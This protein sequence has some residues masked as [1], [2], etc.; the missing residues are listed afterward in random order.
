MLFER[1]QLHL[2]NYKIGKGRKKASVG[3]AAFVLRLFKEVIGDRPLKSVGAPEMLKFAKVVGQLPSVYANRPDLQAL[4]LSAVQAQAKKEKLAPLMLSTQAKYFQYLSTFLNWCVELGD[5]ETN[6]VRFINSARFKDPLKQGRQVFTK[7]D[8][9]LIID[10]LVALNPDE[11]HKFWGPLIA[12]FM[13]LRVNEVCQLYCEDI[14]WVKVTNE[15]N[16][17]EDVVCIRVSNLLP[18]QSV[19]S[20]HSIRHLPIPQRLIDLGFL[21]YVAAVRET[22]S[23]H[24]FPGLAW[25][26]TGPGKALSKWFNSEVLRKRCGITSKSKTFHCFRHTLSTL[27]QR[28]RVELNFIK[29]INGHSPGQDVDSK[30][31]IKAPSLLELRGCLNGLPFGDLAIP[32]CPHDRFNTH[33]TFTAA[34]EAHEERLRA[35]GLEVPR[36]RG[37]PPKGVPSEWMEAYEE[38]KA[39]RKDRTLSRKKVPKEALI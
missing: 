2:D 34:R 15:D 25:G 5:I 32:A 39:Q 29:A 26:E 12:L 4:S 22:G 21:D 27:A 31:Y 30:V 37:R 3:T 1:A 35:N 18:G 10:A 17:E 36:R 8:L 9:E 14:E 20:V 33:L 23:L 24:L 7:K 28:N 38:R 13:S 11:P 19:K 6:P 16:Q